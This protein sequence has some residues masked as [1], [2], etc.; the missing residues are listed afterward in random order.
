[1]TRGLLAG[2]VLAVALLAPWPF[3]SVEPYFFGAVSA[4]VLVVG[5]AAAVSAARNRT[6]TPGMPRFATAVL[7]LPAVA[8]LA[9]VPLPRAFVAL[10]S[11]E[12]VATMERAAPPAVAAWLPVSLH[13][14]AT[15]DAAVVAAAVAVVVLLIAS[16]AARGAWRRLAWGFVAGGVLLA[17]FGLVQRLTQP[18]PQVMFWSIE[19]NER[20]TPFGPYVNRNHFG[21]AMLLFA[22][23]ATGLARAARCSP[24]RRAAPSSDSVC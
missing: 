11:P 23:V 14:H 2:L 5:A 22:G 17:L 1:M 10:V 4:L 8:L 6:G 19:L 13:P 3:G 7:A 18:D 20:G 9:L 16:C 21:G 15:L 12:T 24:R